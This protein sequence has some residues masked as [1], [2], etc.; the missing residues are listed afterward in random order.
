MSMVGPA[1]RLVPPTCLF[2]GEIDG[3]VTSHFR[4]GCSTRAS[5]KNSVAPFIVG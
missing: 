3:H 5:R 2:S 1:Q 4:V